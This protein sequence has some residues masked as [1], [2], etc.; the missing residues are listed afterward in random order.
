MWIRLKPHINIPIHQFLNWILFD[1]TRAQQSAAVIERITNNGCLWGRKNTLFSDDYIEFV[2]VCSTISMN[3]KCTKLHLILFFSLTVFFWFHFSFRFKNSC[4]HLSFVFIVEQ[5][6]HCSST[7]IC[8][9]DS[10][11]PIGMGNGTC[12][13]GLHGRKKQILIFNL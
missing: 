4:F 3:I 5:R 9:N 13:S 6:H 2:T 12:F 1:S 10:H 7:D 8:R 11:T